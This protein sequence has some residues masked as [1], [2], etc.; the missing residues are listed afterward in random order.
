MPY[1]PQA[2][3]LAKSTNKMLQN[4]LR[5]IFNENQTDWDMKLHSALWA[6]QKTYKMSIQT[7]PFWLAFGLEVIMSI[8]FQIPNLRIQVKE[9]LSEKESERI[10]L[11]TL[12]E[13]EEHQIASLL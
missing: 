13:L 1:Y 2:Y 9:W 5:K 8:E 7:T 3:G 10:R 12:C 4:I 11:A 6:Y